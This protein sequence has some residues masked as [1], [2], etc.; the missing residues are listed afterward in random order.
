[1]LYGGDPMFVVVGS[2]PG[3]GPGWI[4]PVSLK[5]ANAGEL[6]VR[7][8]EDG[9]PIEGQIV[10]LEGRP[11]AGAQVKV[12]Q[13]W[14][15]GDTRPPFTE[16]GDLSAWL[17]MVKDRGIRSGDSLMPLETTIATTT[18]HDGSI[19]PDRGRPRAGRRDDRFRADDRP[20]H[21]LCDEPEW[22]GG[23]LHRSKLHQSETHCLPRPRFVDAVAPPSRSRAS[24]ATR[25]RVG[26][27][28]G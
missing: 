2:A 21:A 27:S 15:A 22:A 9:P 10:D 23:P 5:A 16:S 24:S 3:F 17:A 14:F 19:P 20:E 4:P 25:R 12:E 11:V 6:T 26:R 8:V 7:L 18:G 13:V 28:P 1:M